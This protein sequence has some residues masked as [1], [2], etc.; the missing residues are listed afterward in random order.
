MSRRR[1]VLLFIRQN[2]DEPHHAIEMQV[3]QDG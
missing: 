2:H 1:F 3:L